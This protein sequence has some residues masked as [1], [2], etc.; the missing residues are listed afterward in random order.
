MFNPDKIAAVSW[1]ADVTHQRPDH[2]AVERDGM[3][4]FPGGPSGNDS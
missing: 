2:C 3:W 4:H 1:P